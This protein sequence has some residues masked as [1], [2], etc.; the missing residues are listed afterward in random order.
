MTRPLHSLSTLRA[1]ITDDYARLAS[2]QWL[3]VPGGIVCPLG[4][5]ERF[6]VLFSFLL[7]RASLGATSLDNCLFP[8]LLNIFGQAEPAPI[9]PYNMHE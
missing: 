3:T 1:N 7:S 9:T 6:L 2:G 5:T 4:S 8:L